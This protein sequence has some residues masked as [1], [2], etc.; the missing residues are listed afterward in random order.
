MD[1][2]GQWTCNAKTRTVPG[3]PRWLVTLKGWYQDSNSEFEI[4]ILVLFTAFPWEGIQVQDNKEMDPN[5][6]IGAKKDFV[7]G[8]R[9]TYS[10]DQNIPIGK[11]NVELPSK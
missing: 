4:L 2:L 10:V 11:L 1:F 3:K 7:L 5:V 9:L 8:I 6:R